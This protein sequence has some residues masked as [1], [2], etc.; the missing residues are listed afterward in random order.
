MTTTFTIYL[1]M[2]ALIV[3]AIGSLIAIKR[4]PELTLVYLV[5]FIVEAFLMVVAVHHY[6]GAYLDLVLFR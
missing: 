5:L 1:T 3:A 4:K 6:N 2:S